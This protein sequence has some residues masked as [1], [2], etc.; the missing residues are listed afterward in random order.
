MQFDA[1]AARLD[2]LG[3]PHRPLSDGPDIL[4]PRF[5]DGRLRPR[6]GPSR[7]TCPGR[8][9]PRPRSSR[10]SG[11]R[12]PTRPD[13]A[14]VLRR[15]PQR[16]GELPRRQGRSRTTPTP[17]A[18]ALRE[19][20]EEIGLDPVAAGVRVVGRLGAGLDPGQRLPDHADRGRR[21][22]DGRSSSRRPT[23]SPA[24]SSRRSPR[25]CRTRRSRSWSGTVG[26]WP[27]RYGGYRIDDLHVWGATAR[28]LG[29]LGA[30][31]GGRPA[32]R[33]PRG[34]AARTRQKGSPSR[35]VASRPAVGLDEAAL[36]PGDGRAEG[37]SGRSLDDHRRRAADTVVRAGEL[38]DDRPHLGVPSVQ[39]AWGTSG[40]PEDR[41][42]G[43]RP[44][45]SRRPRRPSRRPRSRRTRSCSGW[46]AARSARGARTRAQLT[47]PRPSVWMTWPLMPTVP[48]RTLGSSVADPE[49]DDIHGRGAG[50]RR[51]RRLRVRFDGA[52][53]T[54]A[55]AGAALGRI[56]VSGWAYFDRVK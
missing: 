4:M 23:R 11:R 27:L 26:D 25:S 14:A 36:R 3:D 38:D 18:T 29:Q 20:A 2:L 37:G 46:S 28:I 43:V 39:A 33:P 53:R 51:Q 5:M 1:A 17:P 50:R 45:R 13:R 30:V 12:G 44:G 56:V 7:R 32:G 24:S 19:S 9:R 54:R 52:T 6:L 31:L 47:T 15:L 22:H 48:G 41:L 42:A 35:A 40:R 55:I 8:G 10:T 16:R 49:P 34:R 21:R